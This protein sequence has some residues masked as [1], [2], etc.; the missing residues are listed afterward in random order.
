MPIQR[1]SGLNF[2]GSC[3]HLSI[4]KAEIPFISFSYGDNL[5]AEW[6]YRAGQQVPEDDTPGQ[7]EPE[8]GSLKMSA[9]NAR[10]LLFPLLPQ[11]GAGNVRRVA[12]VSFLHPEIG[13]DSDALIGFR[14]M[15]TK[16]SLEASAKGIEVELKV[17]YRM[18][19]W[20]EKRICFGNPNLTGV[21]GT[22]RI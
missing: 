15:G 22:V 5:K 18:V 9:R 8:E 17:R 13:T 21:S 20:T 12:I 10:S 14:L 3:N 16:T 7:Y 11:F 2:D 4:G 19:A 1:R 6:V